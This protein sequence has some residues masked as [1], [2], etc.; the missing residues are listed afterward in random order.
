M[1]NRNKYQIVI[2]NLMTDEELEE[3]ARFKWTVSV[4]PVRLEDGESPGRQEKNGGE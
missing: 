2:E 1:R 4:K 3:R